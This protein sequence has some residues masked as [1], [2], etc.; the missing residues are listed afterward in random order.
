MWR[1]WDLVVVG[2]GPAGSAAALRALQLR[3]D[4]RV[5]ILDRADFPRDKACGDGVAPHA[6]DVLTSLG[7]APED[8]VD[9]FTPVERLRLTS[10]TGHVAARG[11]QRC[12]Y[13][14]PRAVLD[15]R[16]LSTARSRGAYFRRHRVRTLQRDGDQMVLDGQYRARTVVG[17]DGAES[18]V[19]RLLGVPPNRQG[20]VA[21]AI[22]GYAPVPSG[23]ADE[24]VITMTG[25]RWPA[26]AWSFPIGDGQANVGYGEVL[27][28]QPVRRDRLLQRLSELLPGV[29][30]APGTLRAHRLPL[31][32]SRPR[33]QDGRVLLAGDA[34]S[35]INPMTGEGIFY[36]VLSGALAGEAAVAGAEAGRRY[37]TLLRRR[38]HG[39]LAHTT[40]VSW[41]SGWPRLVDGGLLGAQRDQRVFDDFVELGLG[42]GRLTVRAASSAIGNVVA[43]RIR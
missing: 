42:D 41:L 20:H 34:L 22:R 32:S 33:V 5:L 18:A 30:P 39:H 24:Q 2:G 9:G 29:V 6:L 17:A 16:L 21:V 7:V 3:P 4:A 13:V 27:R 8:I 26:Y 38:L 1:T 15:A 25:E 23:C 40:L 14:I 11:M 19:R 12:A 10:P 37:R 35:L 28:G 31:S 43:G 36:A